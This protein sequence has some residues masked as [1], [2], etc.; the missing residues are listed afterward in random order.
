[1]LSKLLSTERGTF[2]SKANGTA[3][4]TLPP[5]PFRWFRKN[6]PA[7]LVSVFAQP[8]SIAADLTTTRERTTILG[9]RCACG[10]P[11]GFAISRRETH[12]RT[13]SARALS[14]PSRLRFRIRDISVLSTCSV[15]ETAHYH[16][17]YVF[18]KLVTRF[19]PNIRR[20]HYGGKRRLEG[21]S[22]A[23]RRSNSILARFMLDRPR[24]LR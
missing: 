17:Q 9:L 21:C 11:S 8:N 5:S 22:T 15:F 10:T 19:R 2:D 6:S 4:S 24:Q 16:G 14:S 18:H 7:R 12:R 3:R 13:N 1:M 23:P 20:S